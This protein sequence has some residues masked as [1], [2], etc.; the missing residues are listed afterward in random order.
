MGRYVIKQLQKNA[1]VDI[2]IFTVKSFKLC[3]MFFVQNREKKRVEIGPTEN[4]ARQSSF[5]SFSGTKWIII[6]E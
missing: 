3:S 1:K 6:F 5:E 4:N 2:R